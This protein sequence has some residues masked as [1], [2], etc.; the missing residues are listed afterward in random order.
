[1]QWNNGCKTDEVWQR[2][3]KNRAL[4]EKA[5][6]KLA[7]RLKDGE[8]VGA[9][10]GSTSYLTL[11]A[12]A[13]RAER[14][15]LSFRIIPTSIEIE[16]TCS[17]LG[18]P[19]TELKVERPDWSFDGADEVDADNNIIKGRGGAL[20]R[21]KLVIAASPEVYIVIDKSKLVKR[22]GQ[23]FPVPV[24]VHPDAVQLGCEALNKLPGVT[25]VVLRQAVA[26]DGPVITE[27]GNLIFDVYF[28]IIAAGTEQKLKSIIGVVESGLFMG[29]PVTII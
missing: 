25:D 4:K 27:S 18:I 5:A 19:T 23:N 2:D 11:L 13:A 26:K 20:L 9:G 6:R 10:S 14:E 15:G 8:V 29:Y 24:E 7:L 17:T 28:S 12:L 3:I 21:E 1:M 22:L 16:L